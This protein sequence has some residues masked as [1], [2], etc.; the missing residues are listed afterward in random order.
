[1]VAEQAAH[2]TVFQRTPNDSLPAHNRPM[3]PEHARRVK[4]G[5]AEI[6]QSMRESRS[7]VMVTF[8]TQPVLEATAI[9]LRRT[10]TRGSCSPP[11]P[12]S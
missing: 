2:V 9:R 3:E 8:N 10:A 11:D 7:G 6:R 5:Y 4:A 1:M 12:R